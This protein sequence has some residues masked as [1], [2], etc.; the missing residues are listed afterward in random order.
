MATLA[1]KI[2]AMKARHQGTS[3]S[4]TV[5][6][7][8]SLA[9]IAAANATVK[10]PTIELDNLVVQ[11]AAQGDK[12]TEYID[13]QA[14]KGLY[15]M[16]SEASELDGLD[17]DRFITTL[18]N[19]DAATFEKTP[20]IRTFCREIRKNLEQYPELTHIL[21]DEQLGIIVGGYLELKGVE[22]APKTKAAKSAAG[23]RK[24]ADLSK[25]DMSEFF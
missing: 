10:K 19:L 13:A 21:N 22:T 6:P 11:V 25:L 20:D 2:A 8:T 17:A 18:Q 3:T 24:L 23:T 1:E 7:K 9:D 15:D 14:E 16:P 5:K 12:L 4:T